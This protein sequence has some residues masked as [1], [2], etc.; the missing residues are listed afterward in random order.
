MPLV[1]VHAATHFLTKPFEVGRCRA[2][3][4]QKKIAVLLGDLCVAAHEGRGSRR[5]R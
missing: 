1:A 3:G 4:V 2:A 5:S